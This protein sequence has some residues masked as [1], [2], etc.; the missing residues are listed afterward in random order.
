[1]K[2]L[3]SVEDLSRADLDDLLDLADQFCREQRLLALARSP[4][5][6]AQLEELVLVS[7]S[8]Q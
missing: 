1:M 4:E 7:G 2:H 6:A 5:Q 8:S 3:L